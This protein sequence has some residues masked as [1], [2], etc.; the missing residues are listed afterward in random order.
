MPL[1][2]A[3]TAVIVV[4]ISLIPLGYVIVESVDTGWAT[5]SALLFRSRV[6]ELLANT[7][8]LV[9]I[10]VPICVAIGVAAAWLVERTRVFGAKVW[11]VLLA[12]PLAVPAFVNGYSWVTAIPSLGGLRGGV[13]IATLSYFPL[14]YIPVAATLRRLDP[15]VEESARGLGI[16]PWAVFFRVVVPQLRLAIAGGALLVALHLLAEDR[17]SVV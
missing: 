6:R 9:V 15:A 11:A 3:V 4:A 16:G 10:T 14:V 5:A 1:P 12:A 2:L 13:L 7:V 8:M 17:K